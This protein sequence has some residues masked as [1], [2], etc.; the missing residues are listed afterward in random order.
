MSCR[1]QGDATGADHLSTEN[2]VGRLRTRTASQPIGFTATLG[3]TPAPG[4]RAPVP[5]LRI[6]PA[7]E[8]RKETAA[9]TLLRSSC[10]AG[11]SCTR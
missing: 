3:D 10:A 1:E 11:V 8:T 4:R 9:W 6:E 2:A 5:A 7:C